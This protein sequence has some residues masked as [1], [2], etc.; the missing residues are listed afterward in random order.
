MKKTKI[1][2]WL[3]FFTCGFGQLAIQDWYGLDG[4]IA[5]LQDNWVELHWSVFA[6]QAVITLVLAFLVQDKERKLF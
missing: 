3:G 4:Y 6:V 1:T 2:F 5:R